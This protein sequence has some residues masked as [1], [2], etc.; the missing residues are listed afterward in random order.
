MHGLR[1]PVFFALK[2]LAV[3]ISMPTYLWFWLKIARSRS[4]QAN[5][6]DTIIRGAKGTVY[7]T[8]YGLN[9]GDTYAEFVK[10][11]PIF[12][13]QQLKSWIDVEN[14]STLTTN[15]QILFFEPTSGSGGPKKSIPYTKSLLSSF[16]VMFRIWLAD[17]L[18]FGP[19]LK[20]G[21]IYISISPSN[22]Q[23]L[24]DDSAYLTGW[25]RKLMTAFLVGA[26]S[27]RQL[28]DFH[29]FRTALAA[30]LLSEEDLEVVS[31][32][33]PSYF[34]ILLQFIQEN[35]PILNDLLNRGSVTLEGETFGFSPLAAKRREA[36][37][38]DP[39][40]WEGVWPQL[41]LIS[42]WNRA[43]ADGEARVL[44]SVFPNVW[45]QGKGLLATEA[46]LTV[47]SVLAGR[48]LP[49]LSEV[50]LEFEHLKSGEILPLARI[51]TGEVYS[52]L[53]SQKGGLLRYRLRD[54]VVCTGAVL[55]CPTFS[56]C[57]K[58]SGIC[59]LVGE[60]ME[61]AFVT[62]LLHQL[63]IKGLKMVAPVLKKNSER[64]FYALFVDETVEDPEA[65]SRTFDELMCTSYHYQYA[66]NLGQLGAVRL[67]IQPQLRERYLRLA[68]S[69]GVKLGDIKFTSFLD[70][71]LKEDEY[72][73]L[74]ASS[75][76]VLSEVVQ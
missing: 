73:K 47:P 60:K 33:N 25:M 70:K 43:H 14:K 18:I 28:K 22:H 7:Q 12:E 48:D 42:C 23:E 53:F 54:M 21:K 61:G 36:L 15:E 16:N 3:L 27:L 62:E 58:D 40:R 76:Q 10:K 59:D 75:A 29:H 66:R 9:P 4:A 1:S 39:P 72:R 26:P 5:C 44:Q 52:L 65:L 45:M 37:F 63:P 19:R 68:M 2:T 74:S 6:L 31:I 71:P 50:F 34:L 30:T 46:P 11:I 57:G 56:L 8:R 49:L 17:I 35:R 69:R 24:G 67:T 51:K 64:P 55:R 32:W 38:S 13:Y 41:K 20:T